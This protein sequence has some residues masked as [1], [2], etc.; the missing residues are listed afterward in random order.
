[1]SRWIMTYIG[2]DI[3]GFDLLN[4]LTGYTTMYRLLVEVV[5]DPACCS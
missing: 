1:M 3:L 4:Y 5:K 2:I